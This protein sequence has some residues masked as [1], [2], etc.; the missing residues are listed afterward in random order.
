MTA[1]YDIVV[2]IMNN[3]VAIIVLLLFLVRFILR[4]SVRAHERYWAD[5][6]IDGD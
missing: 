2:C 6:I 5:A 4:T 3:E 1:L